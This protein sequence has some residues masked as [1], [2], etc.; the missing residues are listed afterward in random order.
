MP[1]GFTGLPQGCTTPALE[2]S[3][4]W[5]ARHTASVLASSEQGPTSQRKCPPRRNLKMSDPFCQHVSLATRGKTRPN[6]FHGCTHYSYKTSVPS[7]PFQSCFFGVVFFP[8]FPGHRDERKTNGLVYSL[9][10]CVHNFVR[11][12]QALSIQ[13]GRAN[14]KKS[15]CS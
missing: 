2:V 15:L 11:Q 12:P 3:S 13:T 1:A 14:A 10:S 5:P 9:C 8:H 4:G 6:Q 7:S